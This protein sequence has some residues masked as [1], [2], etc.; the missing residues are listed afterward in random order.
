MYVYQGC[1][2][3]LIYSHWASDI[4]KHFFELNASFFVFPVCFYV[5]LPDNLFLTHMQQQ[6]NFHRN[7]VKVYELFAEKN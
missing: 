5:P 1:C 3:L 2:K 7:D 4:C 6:T